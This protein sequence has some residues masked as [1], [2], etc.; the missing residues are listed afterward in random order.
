[1]RFEERISILKCSEKERLE[2]AFISI[3]LDSD[4]LR[5]SIYLKDCQKVGCGMNFQS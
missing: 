2:M 4:E 3:L 1:M 5:L